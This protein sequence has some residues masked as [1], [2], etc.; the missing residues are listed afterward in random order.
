MSGTGAPYEPFYDQPD[1]TE[2]RFVAPRALALI[3]HRGGEYVIWQ[4]RD[5]GLRA[6]LVSRLGGAAPRSR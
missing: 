5:G 3:G 4:K 6:T 2:E 1:P